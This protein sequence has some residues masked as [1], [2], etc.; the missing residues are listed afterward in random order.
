MPTPRTPARAR[1]WLL[2]AAGVALLL[3]GCR[4]DAGDDGALEQAVNNQAAATTALEQRVDAL[5]SQVATPPDDSGVSA[6]QQRAE[7]LQ[8]Q[9]DQLTTELER[10]S[11]ARE[12]GD[13]GDATTG[14]VDDVRSS[15]GGLNA[16]VQ[17]LSDQ[18]QLLR[19]EVAS[20]QAQLRNHTSNHP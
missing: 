8:T 19:E 3:A 10:E 2:I 13:Q 12:Q 18:L 11:T 17:E 5:E 9:I 16:R 6:L 20:L 7:E 4:S 1:R 15:V 14:D